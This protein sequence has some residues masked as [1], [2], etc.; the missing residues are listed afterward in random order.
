MEIWKD[1]KGYE[2]YYEVSSYGRVRRVDRYVNSGIRFNDKRFCKGKILHQNLKRMGYLTVDLSKDNKVKTL[3]THRLVA[4]AFVDNPENKNVVN[5]KNLI[6]TDNHASNLEWVTS[7][8]NSQHASKNGVMYGGLRKSIRC[9]ET[10]QVFPSSY[11][12]AKWLNETKF[13]HSKQPEGMSRNIR[14]CCTGKRKS[15][16]GYHWKDVIQ[17][18]STTSPYGRTFK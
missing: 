6:K 16:F 12:A 18:G 10:G 2:G 8:E 5:H 13:N 11:Q 3:F 14:A 15:A 1:V 9:C 4:T 7:K 17:E